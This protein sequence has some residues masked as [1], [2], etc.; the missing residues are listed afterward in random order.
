MTVE[1]EL[2][3]EQQ[4]LQTV[5]S[6]KQ[7]IIEAQEQ[8]IQAL[9]AANNRLLSALNQLKD[10]CGRPPNGLTPS[11][12]AAQLSLTPENGHFRSSTC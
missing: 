5:V 8:R 7:L 12:V 6:E 4:E 10:R 9:D 3:K 11:Q 1:G 2:R